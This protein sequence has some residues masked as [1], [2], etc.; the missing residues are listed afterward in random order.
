V[1]LNPIGQRWVALAVIFTLVS[2]LAAAEVRTWSDA[3]G[4]HSIEA[5]FLSLQDGKVRLLRPDGKEITLQIEKLS[6]ADQKFVKAQAVRK[7]APAKTEAA[8]V[9]RKLA[10]DFYADLRTK[11]RKVALETLSEKAQELA[12]DKKSALPSLP[13]PDD[14]VNAIK[15]G[16]AKVTG[17]QAEV[18]V[19]VR[20]GSTSQKTTLHLRKD[21]T[22]WR[23]FAI[24]ATLD[25][26]EQTINFEAAVIDKDAEDPLA[27]LLGYEFAVDGYLLDGSPLDMSSY[28]GKVVLIDFWA[29]WC[30]PCRA[31]MPN[32]YAN[33]QKYHD[34]GF[35]VIAVS[36]DQDLAE[37]QKF[38]VEQRPPWAVIA[39]HHPKNRSPMGSKYGIS[40]IP[41]FVLLDRDGK[42]ADVH[43]RGKR[44]EPK[45]A[46]LLAAPAPNSK[47]RN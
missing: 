34:A 25:G 39:D 1:T 24:S 10:D 29:T 17:S 30:G 2:T 12:A 9:L 33:W 14:P 20:V 11:D 37:L 32:I 27:A 36:V 31:E 35:E 40:G 28:R 8:Q 15:V 45:I 42:V 3:S 26:E 4:K 23:V 16:K 43:C 6:K 22:D 21:E 38:V 44:L 47:K 5:E 7:S 19:Q 46:E 41:A 13:S 18:P